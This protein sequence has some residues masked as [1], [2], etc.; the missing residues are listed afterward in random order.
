[1]LAIA[2]DILVIY[3][4]ADYG[5]VVQAIASQMFRPCWLEW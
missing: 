1:L 3:A 4:L 5:T 2:Q